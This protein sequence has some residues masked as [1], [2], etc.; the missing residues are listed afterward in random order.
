MKT[1]YLKNGQQAD[2]IEEISGKFLV[3][4][5]Y[6]IFAEDGNNW[7]EPSNQLK[8]VDMVF[9]VPPVAKID[10][11]VRELLLKKESLEKENNAIKYEIEQRKYD[12]AQI[13]KT[14]IAETKFVINRKELLNAKTIVLFPEGKIMPMTLKSSERSFTGL[15]LSIVIDVH[16]GAERSWGYNLYQESSSCSGQYLDPKYGIMI[17]P[18]EDEV[19]ERILL[20][21]KENKFEPYQINYAPDE[22]LS[23]EQ[24][25]I[26]KVYAAKQ[27]AEQ[28]QSL[29]KQLMEIKSKLESFELMEA[30]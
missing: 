23:A 21:L 3:D 26:R 4:P 28:K 25:E 24:L 13:H 11:E 27:R 9:D 12:L 14:E 22:Y 1:V 8:I 10:A 20:R 6:E 16:T 18:T 30:K 29:E 5:Y 2:L 17:D 19:K 15:R 7:T